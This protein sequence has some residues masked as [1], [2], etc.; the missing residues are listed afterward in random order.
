[1]KGPNL[2]FEI[3]WLDDGGGG[4]PEEVG[5]ETIQRYNLDGAIAAA[6][7]RLAHQ[8]GK[9]AQARGF[10]VRMLRTKEES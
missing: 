4:E 1:M 9:A 10:L 7:N 2:T 5:R 3:V 8:R 6:S